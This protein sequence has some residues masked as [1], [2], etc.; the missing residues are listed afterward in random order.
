MIRNASIRRLDC[1]LVSLLNLY[2]YHP[3]FSF[4]AHNN[5]FKMP[6]GSFSF[7]FNTLDISQ[8]HKDLYSYLNI[9]ELINLTTLNEKK[10]GIKDITKFSSFVCFQ[11]DK[12]LCT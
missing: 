3:N 5:E 12:W 4:R 10:Q 1:F 8:G 9:E 2:L 11:F 6:Q 7:F